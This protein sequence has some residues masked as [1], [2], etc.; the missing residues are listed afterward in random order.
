[1]K[2]RYELPKNIDIETI[3]EKIADYFN[4]EIKKQSD[5]ST[6][7]ILVP[8]K[9]RILQRVEESKIV[10]KVRGA[11]Q[12]AIDFLTELLGQPISVSEEKLSLN[13]FV[14]KILRIPKVESKS[15]EEIIDY[16]DIDAEEFQEYFSKMQR[17]GK[18]GRG[19]KPI[20]D[21]YKLLTK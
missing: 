18:R 7:I 14:D 12:E 2:A 10:F 6:N 21:A 4:T 3:L 19:P 8:S 16:L 9:I 20:L 15:K 5:D 1:M 13:D 11:A 17:F